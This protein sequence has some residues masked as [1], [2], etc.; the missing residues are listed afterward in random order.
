ML[1][2]PGNVSGETGDMIAFTIMAMDA[3]GDPVTITAMGV[4]MGATFTD[5]GGGDATFRWVPGFNQAG[6]YPLTVTASD[7]KGGSETETMGIFIGQTTLGVALAQPLDMAA[8]EGGSA[9]QMLRGYDASGDPLAFEKVSGPAY[10]SVMTTMPGAGLG[11]GQARIAP[12]FG[13][14]GATVGTVAATDG[15]LRHERTFGI[16]VGEA[17]QGPGHGEPPFVP[18][19]PVLTTG[20]TPHTA[21]LGDLDGDGDLDLATA[22]MGSNN[23]SVFPGDGD[24][25]FGMRQ[26]YMTGASPHTVAIGD[27]NGDGKPDLAV[28]NMGDNSVGTMMGRGDGTFMMMRKF[29]M[30]GSPM[31][32]QL[33][34]LDGDGDLDMA[35]SNQSGN[36]MVVM[37]GN[38]DG[39]FAE[40]AAYPAGEHPHGLVLG[41][42]DSDGDLDVV[43]ANDVA[44]TVSVY[45]NHGNGTF[46]RLADF[47]TSSPHYLDAGDWN[48]D[49]RMDVAIA[50]LPKGTVS[51]CLGHGDGTFTQ[52]VEMMTG[53]GAHGVQGEDLDGDGLQDLMVS[54]QSA[55][56]LSVF[57]GRGD[58]TFAPRVNYMANAG[59]HSI[60]TGDLDHDGD[61]DAVVSG[62]NANSAIV[63]INQRPPV[64]A[65]RA[66]AAGGDRAIRLMSDA[67]PWTVN[68]EPVM[69]GF[70]VS[71]VIPSSV[72]LISTGTGSV[73]TISAATTGKP[74]IAA[75]R[76]RNG[77]QDLEVPFAVT[78]LRRLFD[79]L[80]GKSTVT[81]TLQGDLVGG[82]RFRTQLTVK[83]MNMPPGKAAGVVSVAPNPLNPEAVIRFDTERAG[84]VRVR[85]FDP[86]G[87]LVRT[88]MDEP[89]A[90][91]GAHALRFD[92]LDA[93]GARLGSGVYFFRVEEPG[94][95][96][97]GRFAILK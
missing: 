66:F 71:D 90:P 84:A 53:A 83:L 21:A 2:M 36:T 37:R 24:G 42:M 18:P 31:I 46:D 95:V 74:L 38:G 4:P 96:R 49:G 78:D 17:G 68:V 32:L 56:T 30:S 72:A 7:D 88:L 79:Q 58:G 43:M 64:L 59:A 75:D 23:V 92:G 28:T 14:A 35:V 12:G 41:D 52:K 20:M 65:A 97:S 76:D 60:A 69:G 87:R 16:T 50:N 44:L 40:A 10:L 29:A 77:V 73:A 19:F 51:V 26:N 93:R 86:Q 63:L 57:M 80:R 13:D 91:A 11:Y 6:S 33:G 3:D 48:G 1:R 61:P 82:G 27:L 39:T 22:N 34:D 89:S 55:N 67:R 54:N 94:G 45:R 62:I 15:V 9:E 5:L 25:T 8:P 81:A 47:V 70:L 85:I